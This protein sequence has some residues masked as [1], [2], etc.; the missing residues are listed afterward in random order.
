MWNTQYIHM[1]N[2][3]CLFAKFNASEGNK[4]CLKNV[5]IYSLILFRHFLLCLFTSQ[6]TQS[7]I[8]F[9]KLNLWRSKKF[10]D[11]FLS[12]RNNLSQHC[13]WICVF[14]PFNKCFTSIINASFLIYLLRTPFFSIL[15]FLEVNI[16]PP[17][18]RHQPPVSLN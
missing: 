5:E 15:D 9:L 16:P 7:S 4:R 13:H 18:L 2:H 1:K 14:P 10:L 3:C 6:N 8:E 12:S 11:C 17:S